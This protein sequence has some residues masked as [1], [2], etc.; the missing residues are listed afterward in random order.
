MILFPDQG[1]KKAHFPGPNKYLLNKNI[2]SK[3]FVN[4]SGQ[5]RIVIVLYK[6]QIVS[7]MR[8]RIEKCVGHQFCRHSKILKK[9]PL[10]DTLY[11]SMSS[12]LA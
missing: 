12:L 5:T 3:S 2:N 8:K 10:N 9:G 7:M 6:T 1:C 11:S 4:M